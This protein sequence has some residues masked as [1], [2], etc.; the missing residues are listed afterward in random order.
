MARSNKD[1]QIKRGLLSP[2]TAAWLL[3][4]SPNSIR[5]WVRK[6]GLRKVRIPLT[7]EIQVSSLELL[8]LVLKNNLPFKRELFDAARNYVTHFE[9]S[10]IGEIEHLQTLHDSNDNHQELCTFLTDITKVSEKPLPTLSA[11]TDN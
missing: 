7:N 8:V 3:N 2:N 6:Y 4:C 1:Q 10:H 11:E 5:A 9:P